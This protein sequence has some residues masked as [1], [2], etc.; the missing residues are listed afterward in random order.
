MADAT[1][2]DTTR[3][4]PLTG[5]DLRFAAAIAARDSSLI[6]APRRRCGQL[7]QAEW[8]ARC[9]RNGGFVFQARRSGR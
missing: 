3:P 6:A 8:S 9:A 4:T 2:T 7:T 5:D 1:P